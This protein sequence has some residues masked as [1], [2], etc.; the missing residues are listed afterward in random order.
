MKCLAS[1]GIRKISIINSVAKPHKNKQN[2]QNRT[3][4]KSLNIKG[5]NKLILISH[6]WK[7]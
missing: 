5:I 7:R 6:A 3:C 1:G 4:Q 2:N